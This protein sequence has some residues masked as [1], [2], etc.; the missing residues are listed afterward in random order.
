MA[1][2]KA[3]FYVPVNDN[4]GRSLASEIA[5]LEVE[6]FLKFGGWTCLGSSRGAYRMADGSRS[7]DENLSYMVIL[8]DSRI[9]EVEE[10]LRSFRNKTKQEAIYLEIQTSIDVRFVK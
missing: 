5:E 8:D 4:D 2:V 6:L 1:A 3:L 7:L 9:P 10:V